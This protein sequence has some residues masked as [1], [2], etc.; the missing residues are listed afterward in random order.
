[1][2]S[3]L[4]FCFHLWRKPDWAEDPVLPSL[5]WQCLFDFDPREQPA[6]DH[7]GSRRAGTKT[8]T[9]ILRNQGPDVEKKKSKKLYDG[10]WFSLILL[11]QSLEWLIL[12]LNCWCAA[13]SPAFVGRKATA[14]CSFFF[15]RPALGPERP[16]CGIFQ[17]SAS[18]LNTNHRLGAAWRLR[19]DLH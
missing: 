13:H 19:L 12:Y 7:R 16:T 6:T 9:R 3:T 15:H 17:P 14:L 11:F 5:G 10:L 4:A 1:M 18:L 8:L 2:F